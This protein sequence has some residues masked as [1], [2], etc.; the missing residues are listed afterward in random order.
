MVTLRGAG[1]LLPR[2]HVFPSYSD[3]ALSVPS[4][5]PVVDVPSE[6]DDSSS[7]SSDIK[8]T[9]AQPTTEV[10]V[11]TAV[12]TEKKSVARAVRGASGAGR[13]RW[14]EQRVWWRL[15]V[16]DPCACLE[17][18]KESTGNGSGSA[19]SSSF[20]GMIPINDSEQTE[21]GDLGATLSLDTQLRTFRA[22]ERAARK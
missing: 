14:E 9:T 10:N 7:N 21:K 6:Q 18:G 17:E 8:G 16:E 5:G 20:G 3:L 15:S 22:L 4:S 19:A 12:A 11:A 2:S 1:L 13:L